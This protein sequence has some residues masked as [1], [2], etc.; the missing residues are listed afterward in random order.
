M[1]SSPRWL[2][3]LLSNLRPGRTIRKP[4][5]GQRLHAEPL[6]DRC[7]PVASLTVSMPDSFLLDADSDGK[8]DPGDQIRYTVTITNN[9]GADT[10]NT[11]FSMTEDPNAPFI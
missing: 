2:R 5:P 10:A 1:A 4:A 8:G 11:S 9:T 6:E 7:V 3:A